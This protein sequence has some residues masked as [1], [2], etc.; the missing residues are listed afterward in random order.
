MNQNQLTFEHPQVV[1][2]IHH[3]RKKTRGQQAP[4]RAISQPVWSQ[5]QW[6]NP[7]VKASPAQ[8]HDCSEAI[9]TLQ[10]MAGES[11][12]DHDEE[13][14]S[15]SELLIV[16]WQSIWQALGDASIDWP[17]ENLVKAVGQ[18]EML[19]SMMEHEGIISPNGE[20]MLNSAIDTIIGYR[21]KELIAREGSAGLMLD[22]AEISG[23]LNCAN[24][25]QSVN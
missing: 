7:V 8:T 4:A 14:A 2:R 6:P 24:H 23:G 15:S 11:L 17:V 5:Q 3:S 9:Q 1:T 22:P 18:L 16:Y 25:E 13:D 21:I 19:H 20:M 10:N 12:W